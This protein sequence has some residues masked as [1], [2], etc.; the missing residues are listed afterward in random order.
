M[1]SGPARSPPFELRRGG[2]RERLHVLDT[3]P[4]RAQSARPA[5]RRACVPA[6][7]L[8]H[9]P[10]R[11]EAAR[12]AAF[13]PPPAHRVDGLGEAPQRRVRP[14]EQHPS[15][16][17]ADGLHLLREVFDHRAH[18][19]SGTASFPPSSSAATW[20]PVADEVGE[21]PA[22][23]TPC[24]ENQRGDRGAR[25]FVRAGEFGCPL[26]SGI[27]RGTSALRRN[28]SS[29]SAAACL[30]QR[31]DRTRGAIGVELSLLTR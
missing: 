22:F 16:R 30:S 25:V 31:R 24:Y 2:Q 29:S 6:P 14:R 17:S 5:C 7:S 19:S 18:S 28:A 15:F 11:R 4:A 10:S 23:A 20:R 1:R 3:V 12:R 26:C 9:Q 8:L 21:Y 27:A 13:A